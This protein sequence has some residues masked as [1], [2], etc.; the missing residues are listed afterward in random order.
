LTYQIKG[1]NYEDEIAGVGNKLKELYK[2]KGVLGK[3][4][5][6]IVVLALNI[7]EKEYRALKIIN[8]DAMSEA[9]LEYIKSE[10]EI[11]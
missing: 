1:R 2:M 9:D 4:Q 11:L 5:F 3:G 7:S 10:S 8:K 6:G